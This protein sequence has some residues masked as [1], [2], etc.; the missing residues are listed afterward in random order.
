MRRVIVLMLALAAVSSAAFAQDFRG[1]ITGRITDSSSARMPGVTVVATNVDTNV[2]Q[3][4]ITN[5][6]GDYS[7]LYLNPGT[8][9]VTAGSRNWRVPICRCASARSSASI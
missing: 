3:T 2:A 9:T 4:T 6:E 7:I 1:A 5:S 8:Y